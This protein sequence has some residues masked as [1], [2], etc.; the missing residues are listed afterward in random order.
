MKNSIDKTEIDWVQQWSLFAENFRDG[1]AHI[2]L[3]GKTLLLIPGAGFGDLSH[4]TTR[5]MIDLLKQHLHQQSVIDIGTGSGILALAALVLGAKSAIGIDIDPAAIK[6]AKQNAKLNRLK[7]VFAKTLPKTTP[8]DQIILMNMI[9]S[10]QRQVEHARLNPFA[11]LWIVSGIL[12]TQ[13]EKYLTQAADWG[14]DLLSEQKQ[15]EWLG[16]VFKVRL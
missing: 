10:E 13:R 4:P 16:F 14:W 3:G 12:E 11:K 6:H 5:L 8:K 15:S 7:A 1:K 9:L 2:D